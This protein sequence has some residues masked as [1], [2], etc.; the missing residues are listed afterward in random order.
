MSL[1]QISLSLDYE[2]LSNLYLDYE[3]L[4]SLCL[5]GLWDFIKSLFAWIVRFYHFSVCLDYGILPNLCLPSW[6]MGFYPVSVCLDSGPLH[7]FVCLDFGT[8]P[9]PWFWEVRGEM[10]SDTRHQSLPTSEGCYFGDWGRKIMRTLEP[11]LTFSAGKTDSNINTGRQA[12]SGF[13]SMLIDKL[14]FVVKLSACSVWP[15]K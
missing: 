8:A 5:T 13:L 3:I 14:V 15:R 2:I 12:V 7:V 11:S 10:S 6:I 9:K 4:S 1:Y